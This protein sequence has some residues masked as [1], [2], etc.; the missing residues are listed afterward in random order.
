[1]VCW[2][3]G[4]FYIVRLFV[5]LTE[6]YERPQAEQ[7][8]LLPQLKLMANRLWY[9]ITWPSAIATVSFGS[10]MLH[11]WWPPPVWLQIK[12]LAVAGL[13]AYHIA[14]HWIHG[15]LQA[16]HPPWTSRSLRI[17][18]EVATLFLVGIVFVVVLK[19]ALSMLYA[20]AGLVVFAAVLMLGI[21]IYRRIRTQSQG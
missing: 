14:C 16:G 19:D 17:W 13:T 4:L 15:R 2:F 5:Y 9:G 1:V 7:D 18:N 21:V 20:I 6:T 11:T 12:L 8:V 3:A 10:A